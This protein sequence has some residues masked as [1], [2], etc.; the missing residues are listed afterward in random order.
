MHK[1]TQHLGIQERASLRLVNQ[2]FNMTVPCITHNE[3]LEFESQLADEKP[4]T[5]ADP[6]CE[7]LQGAER[8]IYLRFAYRY[9]RMLRDTWL[10]CRI[11]LCLR[12]VE[13]YRDSRLP[14]ALL[15]PG[16]KAAADRICL[17][18]Q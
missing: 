14:E 17:H 2:S 9:P 12:T 13:R 7:Y 5:K 8:Y 3:F 15:E 6:L 4:L 16:S 11:C 18:C 1:T 10:A